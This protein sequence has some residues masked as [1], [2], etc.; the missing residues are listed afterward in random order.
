MIEWVKALHVISVIAW[1]AG[2][3]YLPRLF[4]YHTAAEKG[5]VQSETFKIMERRLFR[6]ITTPAMIATWVFG[7]WMVH[8]G[9]VDWGSVWPWVKA[10]MV[11]AL[12]GVHG[13]YARHLKAFARDANDKPQKYFRMLNEVPTVLM[14]VIVIMVIV[15]PF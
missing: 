3:L 5:S 15:K 9:L 10:A 8:L 14:I 6:A 1:M 2:M 11:L 4:V 12:S 7:L 13:L